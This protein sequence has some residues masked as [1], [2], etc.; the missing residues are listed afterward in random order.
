M[1]AGV[2]ADR[3]AAGSCIGGQGLSALIERAY[4]GVP[5]DDDHDHAT[6]TTA[7]GGLDVGGEV[8]GERD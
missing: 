4:P 3:L 2:P 8:Q 7:A 1:G 6:A 5:T